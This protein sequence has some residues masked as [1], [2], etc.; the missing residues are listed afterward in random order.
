MDS[1]WR[2]FIAKFARR[3]EE[4]IVKLVQRGITLKY[5]FLVGGMSTSAAIQHTV[6][7]ICK[8][9]NINYFAPAMQT[10]KYSVTAE[11]AVLIGVTLLDAIFTPENS[12]EDM[13]PSASS[14]DK[15][16]S[17]GMEE[18]DIDDEESESSPCIATMI[19]EFSR[20]KSIRS[21]IEYLE[22]K[23]ASAK[24]QNPDP[25]SNLGLTHYIIVMQHHLG[26][27]YLH[28]CRLREACATLH[29]AFETHKQFFGQNPTLIVVYHY[30]L[31]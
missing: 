3:I 2:S 17:S 23:I 13:S 27:A 19:R 29:E 11:S 16:C 24:G 10:G 31:F 25:S 14:D 6:G 12:D 21:Q 22:P 18:T 8:K 1:L 26:V 20:I 15:N 28:S 7:D 4:T 5:L 30:F 9:Y